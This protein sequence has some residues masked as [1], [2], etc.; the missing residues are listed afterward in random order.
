MLTYPLLAVPFT[1]ARWSTFR[2]LNSG[3]T[4]S[5]LPFTPTVLF[6]IVINLSGE[7]FNLGRRW[8]RTEGLPLGLFHVLLFWH[9]RPRLLSFDGRRPTVAESSHRISEDMEK[10][11]FATKGDSRLLSPS[12]R[13][14]VPGHLQ[15]PSEPTTPNHQPDTPS[16]EKPLFLRLCSELSAYC[17]NLPS[18]AIWPTMPRSDPSQSDKQGEPRSRVS[19]RAKPLPPL[20]SLPPLQLPVHMNRSQSDVDGIPRDVRSEKVVSEGWWEMADI[21][22]AW[23]NMRS[24]RTSPSLKGGLVRP[25]SLILS[26]VGTS[27]ASMK[28]AG[29]TRTGKTGLSEKTGPTALVTVPPAN[30]PSTSAAYI[31]PSSWRF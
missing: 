18:S 30:K 4:A 19:S 21:G 12:P 6:T 25:D 5:N 1:A 3:A 11:P 8:R 16:K 27:A 14:P 2:A 28:T 7:L 24:G 29:S 23:L 26:G 31:P 9:L 22:N 10:Q 17:V 13:P 20:P 15:L